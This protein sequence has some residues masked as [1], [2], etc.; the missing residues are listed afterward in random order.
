MLNIVLFGP[1]GAGKGTQSE[2]LI[3]KYNL[4]HLSTGDLFR[5]H[6]G[7]GT[8]L[9]KLARKYMDEGKLVPDEVVIGMVET[10]IKDTLDSNGFIFDGFPRTVAQ[11][12]ALDK[13]LG[14][15]GL[16]ISGMIAL[17]VPEDVLKSRIHERGK[18]SGRVDDQDIA[19]IET[20]IKVYLDET[21]P[22]AGFY[23]K[24]GKLTKIHGVG[25]ID[26]IFSNISKVIDQ[27]S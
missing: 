7:E 25:T 3:E 11:A 27:Y 21:L 17:D 6:L 14:D 2:K 15:L 4:T 10:K 26:E 5:K 1:P 12:E 20:R 16:K 22:V 19:K 18:T 23:D 8:D 24:Q 9:G 13:V